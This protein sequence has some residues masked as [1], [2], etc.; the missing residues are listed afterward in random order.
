[1]NMYGV[2][3]M[4]EPGLSLCDYLAAK[5]MEAMVA[6]SRRALCRDEMLAIAEDSY[7]MAEAMLDIRKSRG[8]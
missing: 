7:N 2:S 8:E 6:R 4:A 5:A 1:M 3:S